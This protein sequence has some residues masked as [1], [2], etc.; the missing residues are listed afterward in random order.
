MAIISQ[1]RKKLKSH[2][3]PETPK[4]MLSRA[5]HLLNTRFNTAGIGEAVNIQLVAK[6]THR[7]DWEYVK[8]HIPLSQHID[9]GA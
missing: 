4:E 5:Q 1:M 6:N 3:Q 9:I 2:R 8:I 7:T